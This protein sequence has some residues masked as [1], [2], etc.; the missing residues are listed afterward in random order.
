MK[1][2]CKKCKKKK[3]I[4]KEFERQTDDICIDCTNK[5]FDEIFKD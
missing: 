1:K 5:E 3:D 2:V 4:Y